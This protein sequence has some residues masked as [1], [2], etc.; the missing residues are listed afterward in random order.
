MTRVEHRRDDR[1]P[2]RPH[3]VE[4]TTDSSHIETW[5]ALESEAHRAAA[6]LHRAIAAQHLADML[7]ALVRAEHAPMS[8]RIRESACIAC[9]ALLDG[10]TDVVADAHPKP[11]DLSL[12]LQ[13]GALNVYDDALALRAPTHLEAALADADERVR[14]AREAIARVYRE[15]KARPQT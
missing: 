6:R 2:A 11:G 8:H 9:G 4:V 15:D 1:R 13:C 10:W 7:R 3:C 5:H 12:C 14:R